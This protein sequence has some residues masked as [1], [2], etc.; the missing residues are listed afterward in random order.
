MSPRARSDGGE[1]V[2]ANGRWGPPSEPLDWF[3]A[4]APKVRPG[5]NQHFSYA[6]RDDLDPGVVGVRVEFVQRAS[7]S[8]NDG[9]AHFGRG[10]HAAPQIGALLLWAA[11]FFK[12]DI[13]PLSVLAA[14]IPQGAEVKDTCL[15]ALDAGLP[16]GQA[17]WVGIADAASHELAMGTQMLDPDIDDPSGG[18]LCLQRFPGP[19]AIV[20]DFIERDGVITV[21]GRVLETR[22]CGALELLDVDRRNIRFFG[23]SAVGGLAAD[24]DR[25]GIRLADWDAALDAMSFQ[26]D[27]IEVVA[28]S[29]GGH[30]AEV[31]DNGG[32]MDSNLALRLV[33]VP[34]EFGKF[35]ACLQLRCAD[36]RAARDGGLT[37]LFDEHGKRMVQGTVAYC[38]NSF[39]VA[40]L[41][42][43]ASYTAR[44]GIQP[45]ATSVSDSTPSRVCE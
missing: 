19:R 13:D 14:D 39:R 33:Q 3:A 15:E 4:V 31:H 5:Q 11:H 44:S 12:A 18:E 22:V 26:L 37:D 28:K 45:P 29:L 7:R 32:G 34:S 8:R 1:W 9:I 16:N 23:A 36:S 17:H 24:F 25:L 2:Q 35:G 27:W 20:A 6:R 42:G 10:H 38:G 40:R 41:E 43:T 30:H 21:F